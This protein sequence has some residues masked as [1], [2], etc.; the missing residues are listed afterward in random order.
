[1]MIEHVE[2]IERPIFVVI[3]QTVDDFKV[4]LFVPTCIVQW[5][6]PVVIRYMK[7]TAAFN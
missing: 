4:R 1:M 7:V 5:R 2:E 6:P 3:E